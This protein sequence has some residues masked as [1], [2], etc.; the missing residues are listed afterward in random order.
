MS[1]PIFC[2][3]CGYK[4]TESDTAP[5]GECAKCGI[6]FAKYRP[7]PT[8]HS[9]QGSGPAQSKQGQTKVGTTLVFGLLIAGL[10]YILV[11]AARQLPTPEDRLR[12]I[13][14]QVATDA[15]NQ[16]GMVARSGTP[17][18]ICV[19]AGLVAA[20]YLQANDEEKYRQWKTTENIDCTRANVPR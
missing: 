11:S 5:I 20:A 6:I 15:L 14:Y 18:D 19:H 10:A 3:K 9:V 7:R 4:R 1:T 8:T 12:S 16:Y 13:H 17:I 2:P